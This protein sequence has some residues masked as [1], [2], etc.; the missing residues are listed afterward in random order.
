M[1]PE[2]LSSGDPTA[3]TYALLILA[4][5]LALVFE[6]VNG[7][8]DT[9]NAVATVIY[10]RT[11]NPTPAVIWSGIWNLIGVLTSS[12]AVAF[13]IL[14]LLPVDLILNIG[15]AGGF[16]MV[17]SLLASAIL[18]N[19]GTWY[20]GLPASSSHTLIGSILGVGLA[21]ALMGPEHS[22]ASGFNWG[23]VQEVGLGLMIS[24]LIGFLGAALLL[25]AAK[26]L[27]RSP[28]LYAPPPENGRPSR[29]TRGLLILTCT[30]VSFAHGSNDGQKG[31]GLVLLILIGILPGSFALKMTTDPETLSGI[32]AQAIALA[33]AFR[34]SAQGQTVSAAETQ[35]TLSR[36]IKSKGQPSPEVLA[37]SASV[38]EEIAS[39]LNGVKSLQELP[40][41]ERSQLRNQ[42]YL[43]SKAIG[44]LDRAGALDPSLGIRDQQR[45]LAK[46]ADQ[47]TLFIPAWV[48]YAVALALG[49]GTMIGYQR[50]VKTVGEKI[51]KE[52]LTYAQGASAECMAMGTILMADRFGLPISTTHVLSS[53]IAGTMAANRSGLQTATVRN[54]LIAWVLTLPVCVFLGA[55]LFALTLNGIALFLRHF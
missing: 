33:P 46:S 23:K 24:P 20:W 52:K 32:R 34:S 36:F 13:G 29:K 8:H 50:I 42:L 21:N 22:L 6:F 51:G 43:L 15:S 54:V 48:K 19:V 17:F 12:G 25:I 26:R 40:L 14:A 7:F 11:L 35:A 10:T 30:G 41:K 9:A 3:L 37:A 49:L 44:K 27:V 45:A 39:E 18:W 28:E 2:I 1:S 31:M 53:G 47:I 4:V 16:A 5:G 55:L 38:C